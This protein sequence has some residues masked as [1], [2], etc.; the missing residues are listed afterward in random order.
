MNSHFKTQTS[1]YLTKT[2]AAL[3]TTTYSKGSHLFNSTETEAHQ[4]T[5]SN[6]RISHELKSKISTEQVPQPTTYFLCHQI[7]SQF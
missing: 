2:K 4:F 5:F 3:F 1:K 7:S 6:N